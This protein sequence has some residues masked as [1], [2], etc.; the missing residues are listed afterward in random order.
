MGHQPKN[1][2][3][4]SLAPAI[5]SCFHPDGVSVGLN[6]DCSP[7]GWVTLTRPVYQASGGISFLSLESMQVAIG[8]GV[9]AFEE[10]IYSTGPGR[11][12]TS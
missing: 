10:Y 5:Y 1:S 3:F 4:S 11:T 8:I 6:S 2:E 12:C 9:R 7:C